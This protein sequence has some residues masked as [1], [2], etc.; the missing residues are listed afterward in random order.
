MGLRPKIAIVVLCVEAAA[1]CGTV[2]VGSFDAAEQPIDAAL[3][4]DVA[5]PVPDAES[6]V[7]SPAQLRARW[8]AES[9][10]DEETG[11][12]GATALGGAAYGPG[13]HGSAFDLDGV[14]DLLTADATDQLW[15]TA[16]FSIEAWVRTN[17]VDFSGLFQ[18]YDCGGSDGCGSALWALYLEQ[19]IPVFELRVVSGPEFRVTAWA[20]PVNDGEWHHLVGVRDV[21]H[22]REQDRRVQRTLRWCAGRS[23]SLLHGTHC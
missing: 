4:A 7:Q 1:A 20:S 18:K 15:P 5:T 10:G 14:D 11:A 3:E 21:D 16:S 13:R 2:G 17:A 19:G 6:C 12:H 9:N 22:T 23:G 8:R